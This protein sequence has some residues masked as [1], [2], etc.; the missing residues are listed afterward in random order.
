MKEI[1]GQ[2]VVLLGY[3]R[4][5]QS[6]HKYL[7]ENYPDIRIGISDQNPVEP[8]PGTQTQ[9]YVGSTYLDDLQSYDTA[10]R[11]PGIPPHTPELQRFKELGKWVTT[12]TNIFFSECPGT[13]VG[14]T[15]TK[16]KSTTA[17]LVYEI[18]KSQYDDSR[19]V[20]NIGKPALDS[21]PEATPS[22]IFIAELSSYQLED[23]RYSPH[24]SVVLAITPEHINYHGDFDSYAT[25]KA[26][27][28]KHQSKKDMVVFNPDHETTAKKTSLSKSQKFCFSLRKKQGVS[29][30]VEQGKIYILNRR[31]EPKVIMKVDEI[32]LLG[33][34]NLENTLAAVSVGFLVGI[35]SKKTREAIRNFKPLPNRLEFVQERSG[36]RFYNDSLATTPEA[37]IH[38]LEALGED[39]ETLIAG[40]YDRG[41]DFSI[42]AKFL[43]K[44]KLK[45]LI[46]FPE[47]GEKIWQAIINYV[48]PENLPQKYAVDSMEQAVNVA[49]SNTSSGKIC[50]LSPG[51]ASFNLFQDYE[52]RGNQFKKAI[53]RVN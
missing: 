34:G 16:G 41:L 17:S 45:N 4:E 15:G 21:L 19:L 48:N 24:I 14:I 18:I 32:P 30:Y 50:I 52:D 25:A 2:S 42:L 33:Q 43:S 9:M 28:V 38:A 37:V 49:I 6:T 13:I 36:I 35:S 5:G 39:V 11:S 31:G 53:R 22:T 12:E 27:I 26:N 44:R 46:L 40:G 47:T 8:I 51:S 1:K 3:G 20:G 7:L 23:I 10:I 29:C